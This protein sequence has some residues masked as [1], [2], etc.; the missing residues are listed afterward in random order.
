MIGKVSTFLGPNGL[1][2]SGATPSL[3]LSLD[4][5]SSMSLGMAL[6]NWYDLSI[7]KN[8]GFNNDIGFDGIGSTPTSVVT[9]LVYNGTS[10]YTSFTRSNGIPLG[11]SEYTIETWFNSNSYGP[12]EQGV[13]VGWGT[14]G[15]TNSTNVLR[16][17]GN[18]LYTYWWDN[19]LN[20]PFTGTSSMIVG[21]WYYAA[22]TYDGANRKLYLNGELKATDTPGT[23]SV[24][25]ASNLQIGMFY[26]NYFDGKISKVKIVDKALNS[27]KILSNFNADKVLYG[28]SFGSMTFNDT[29]SPYLISTSN[30]YSFGTNDF[31]VEAFFKSAT[32]SSS[33]A[34]IV[35]LRDN[36]SY[37]SGVGINLQSA[38]GTNPLIEFCVGSMSSAPSPGSGV[39]LYYIRLLDSTQSNAIMFTGFFYVDDATH[40]VQTFYNMDNPTVDIR[41]TG[42]NGG[43]TYLYY[44]G[45]LCFDGGGCNITSFPYLYGA[46]T[47]DYNLYGESTSSVGNVDGYGNVTY[48]FSTTPFGSYNSSYTMSCTASNNTWYHVAISRTGGTSSFFVNGDL[49]GEV[50]DNSNYGNSNLSIGKYYT[51]VSDNYFNG[52]ISNVRVVNG[53]GLYTGNSIRI[54]KTQLASITNTKFLINSQKTTPS[55]DISGLLHTVTASNIGWTASL[56]I[57]DDLNYTNFASTDGLVLVGTDGISNNWIYLTTTGMSKNGNVYSDR[58]IRYNRNFSFEFQFECSGGYGADGFCVQWATT[59]NSNGGVGGDVSVIADS[60]T[61]NAL[62]FQTWSNNLLQWLHNNSIVTSSSFSGFNIRQNVYYWMDYNY[63]TSTMDIYYSTSSTKPGSPQKTFT[64]FTFDSGLYYIGFGAATGGSDDN[65]ILKSMKLTF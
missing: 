52:V 2:R 60:S 47:G 11:N 57:F 28:Y 18:G 61:I 35:S 24:S 14:Y 34:G 4:T 7:R 20:I 16:L 12:S 62:K 33:S 27:S 10:S 51:N 40:V 59:N 29:Q 38:N 26:N 39:S 17:N 15:L 9:S 48:E 50:A 3:V 53:T 54:P 55:A 56:P 45:W 43:P 32:N 13:L 58:A 21:N 42:G 6:E 31:T 63:G 25:D 49:F 8:N 44:P 65:H 22:S 41:S 64:S 37:I 36:S 46:S 5:M 19:D 1:Y 23:H 30:D